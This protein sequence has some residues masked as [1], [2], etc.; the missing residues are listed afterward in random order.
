MSGW[1]WWFL[2]LEVEIWW[3][4]LSFSGSFDSVSC[5]FLTEKFWLYEVKETRRKEQNEI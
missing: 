5:S 2:V 3:I 1:W 4:V